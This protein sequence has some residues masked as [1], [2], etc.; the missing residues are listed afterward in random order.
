MVSASQVYAG[1]IKNG[2]A[3]LNIYDYFKARAL[4]KKAMKHDSVASCYGLSMI[5]SRNDNHFYNIDSSYFYLL[6]AKKL[7]PSSTPR[8]RIKWAQFGLD[9]G[10]ILHMKDT[11]ELRAFKVALGINTIDGY[12]HYIHNYPT[13][14]QVQSAVDLRD[15]IAFTKAEKENTYQA[16]KN[17]MDTYL[18]STEYADAKKRYEISLFKTL[19]ADHNINSF[20][21]F[22]HQYPE[23]PYIGAA[24]DSVYSI[25][26][27][28]NMVSEYHSF[29]KAYPANRNVT[30]AWHKLYT[31]YTMDGKPETF[32]HFHVQFPDYPYSQH[33]DTDLVFSPNSFLPGASK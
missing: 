13:A 15:I 22:I 24:Q 12:N 20:V 28:H 30:T 27:A 31:I 17:Y 1:A 5:L 3:A 23:S 2:F 9:S 7:Y 29:V 4:F 8:Q 26:T 11:I 16:Y 18:N 6:K 32:A 14:W 33:A 21:Q 19:T 10:S 25:A